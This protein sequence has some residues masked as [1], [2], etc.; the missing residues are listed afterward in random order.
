MDKR[1]HGKDR[2]Q[3]KTNRPSEVG[4]LVFFIDYASL[5][6][7]Y[8]RT[9]SLPKPLEFL[10]GWNEKLPESSFG[11]FDV[12]DGRLA[13]QG[14]KVTVLRRFCFRVLSGI[15]CDRSRSETLSCS[16]RPR[17][18]LSPTSSSV[19]L[20]HL[21]E[22][23]GVYPKNNFFENARILFSKMLKQVLLKAHK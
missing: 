8:W 6:L 9:I 20:V 2:R 12:R 23:A 3:L 7:E 5:V 11:E 4:G 18:L 19:C 1:D 13:F 22:R 17:I 21:F 10:F 15:T 16:W 14:R